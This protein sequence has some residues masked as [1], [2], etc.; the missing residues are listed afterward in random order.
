[1]QRADTV[2]QRAFWRKSSYSG[3]Q[4]ECVEVASAPDLVGVRDTKHRDGG[5][6]HVS[7]QCWHTFTTR[8]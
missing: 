5:T 1:M 8:V 6:L 7:A 2:F 3:S 4:T